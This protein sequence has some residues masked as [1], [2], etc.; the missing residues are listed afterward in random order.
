MKKI[1]F[2]FYLSFFIQNFNAQAEIINLQKEEKKFGDW[3]VFCEIDTMMDVAHCKIGTKFYD[4][5][6]SITIEPSLKSFSQFFIVVPKIKN[7]DFLQIKIGQHD[8]IL[9]KIVEEKDFGLV[10]IEEEQKQKLFSQMKNSDFLF[11]RFNV[12]DSQKEV[13]AKI[14]LSDFKNALNYCKQ[15]GSK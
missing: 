8:L 3:K 13:T 1:F 6:S 7:G 5:A 2:V 14:N 4:G 15:R 12:R 10:V 11:L 9:S